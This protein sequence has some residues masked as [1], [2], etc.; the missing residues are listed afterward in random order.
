MD[1]ILG[2]TS[3]SNGLSIKFTRNISTSATTAT[4]V[5]T[6]GA[7]P[8]GKSMAI[9]LSSQSLSIIEKARESN[10]TEGAS[11]S[12]TPSNASTATA[13]VKEKLENKAKNAT[14]FNNGKKV[15]KQIQK[16]TE[17]QEELK[18]QQQQQVM[19]EPEP[20]MPHFS[21]VNTQPIK[22]RK[23]PLS[24]NPHDY[25]DPNQ[26]ACLLCQRKFKSVDVLHKHQEKSELHISNLKNA[27]LVK[28]AQLRKS[29]LQAQI[30]SDNITYRDRAAERREIYGQPERPPSHEVEGQWS[31]KPRKDK[32]RRLTWKGK[33]HS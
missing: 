16:W 21:S 7:E 25:G 28:E 18:Q 6:D 14:T 17:R 29:K 15:V 11:M 9:R 13:L 4:A 23:I 10:G 31:R 1:D 19:I 2:S 5:A 12:S 20:S 26:L 3:L 32:S 24:D 30:V 33:Y 22:E 8:T 27:T